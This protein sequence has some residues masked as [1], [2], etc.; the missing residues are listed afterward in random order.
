MFNL[1]EAVEIIDAAPLSVLGRV[2]SNGAINK[3]SCLVGYIA[4]KNP[5]ASGVIPYGLITRDGAAGHGE[6]SVKAVNPTAVRAIP[7]G[8]L[9]TR[10]G[11]VGHSEV[12]IIAVNSAAIRFAPHGLIPIDN[13][14]GESQGAIGT[15][16]D[17][18]AVF[19][20]FG[21]ATGDGEVTKRDNRISSNFYHPTS[22]FFSRICI[23][24]DAEGQRGSVDR[25]VSLD[26]ELG[27][28]EDDGPPAQAGVE[29]D[30]EV[31]RG[32][33]DG[34]AERDVAV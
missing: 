23:D 8:R 10:D 14:V 9:I 5:A 26:G 30:S 16:Q 21:P 20:V 7:H 34:F 25:I 2:V 24:G 31:F 33:A 12:S 19:A 32:V 22:V 3:A 27:F 4:T 28:R 13:T 1:S 15:V 6:V 29:F 11:A 18:T 17:S